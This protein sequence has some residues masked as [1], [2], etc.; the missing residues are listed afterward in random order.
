MKEPAENYEK[1]RTYRN[2]KSRR[3]GEQLEHD[4]PVHRPYERE[5]KNWTRTVDGLG[6]DW[7]DDEGVDESQE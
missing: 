7:N 3:R 4:H 6:E 1:P 2:R 5:H